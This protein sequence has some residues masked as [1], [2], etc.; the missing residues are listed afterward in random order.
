MGG[1]LIVAEGIFFCLFCK[2]LLLF[3]VFLRDM[4]NEKTP[5]FF[6]KKYFL[7]PAGPTG[8]IL[9]NFARKKYRADQDAHKIYAIFERLHSGLK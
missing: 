9:K 3:Y 6:N 2:K 4:T 8:E 7:L 5:D 1:F